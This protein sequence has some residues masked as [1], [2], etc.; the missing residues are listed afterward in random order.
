MDDHGN[1]VIVYEK[2]GNGHWA[3][4]ARRFNGDGSVGGEIVL[5]NTT[6]NQTQPKVALEGNAGAFVVA[7]DS[8]NEVDVTRISRSD[9]VLDTV[10]A[11]SMRFGPAISINAQNQFLVTYSSYTSN[12][13]NIVGRR[14]LL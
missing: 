6:T 11:G 1:A 9:V 5:Q 3:A 10:S 2:F 8:G 4:E 7:Y 13:T 14:G 12:D